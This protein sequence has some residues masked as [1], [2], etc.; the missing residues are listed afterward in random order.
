MTKTEF[1]MAAALFAGV[2]WLVNA[3]KLLGCDFDF[4]SSLRCEV[5]HVVGVV[6]PPASIMTVWFGGDDD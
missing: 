5:I 4:E 3:Y 1:Y 6:V 2:C